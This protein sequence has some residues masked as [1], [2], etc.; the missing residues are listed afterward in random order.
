[1]GLDIRKDSYN[2][3]VAEV[4]ISERCGDELAGLLIG[5]FEIVS[6]NSASSITLV[7]DNGSGSYTVALALASG[8]WAKIRVNRI[9]STITTDISG[10][11]IL[12]A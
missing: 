8:E 1:M 11:I 3:S 7:T 12:D 9:V 5:D 6:T 2:G 10:N 4:V